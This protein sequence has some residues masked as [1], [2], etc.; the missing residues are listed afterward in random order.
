LLVLV[1]AV[2]A[3]YL[4]TRKPLNQL[5]V[6]GSESM[7]TYQYSIYGVE[8]PLG[9]AV[10]AD[11]QRIYV[12][13]SAGKRTVVEFDHD[14]NQLKEF[15]APKG[16][17][18]GNL[19]AYVAINPIDG[20]VAVSDTLAKAVYVYT[21]DGVYQRTVKPVGLKGTWVPLGLAYDGAGNLYVTEVGG[22]EHRLLVLDKF[23]K[24][25]RTI[26]PTESKMTFPNGVAVDPAGNVFLADSN[27]GRL[28]AFS[29]DGKPLAAANR[30]VGEGDLGLP[31]GVATD[32]GDRV[33]V[34]DTT[35]QGVR[36]YK[37]SSDGTDQL[38][39][40][41]GFGDEGIADGLFEYPNGIAIDSRSNVYVT[42]RE[43]GRVQV[44]S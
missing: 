15:A 22:K 29:S 28:L 5:P 18:V 42:D 34:V 30:G 44:W 38:T 36:A 12:T 39:F 14:G 7:P 4:I 25:D 8:K 40:I 31:R 35:N 17:K 27:N 16:S 9:V 11:G 41:G 37:L 21:G 32:P 20:S 23:D 19:P 3:W 43:N 13:Q 10:S 24:V 26:A 6:L 33:Y 1:I 2:L